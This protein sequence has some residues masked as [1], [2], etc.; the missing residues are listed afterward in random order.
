MTRG[1]IKVL[2]QSTGTSDSPEQQKEH[3]CGKAR[4]NRLHLYS[5]QLAENTSIIHKSGALL[6]LP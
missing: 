5:V 6:L 1:S 3:N 2:L 4:S